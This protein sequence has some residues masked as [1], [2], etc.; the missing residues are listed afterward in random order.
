MLLLHILFLWDYWVQT[1]ESRIPLKPMLWGVRDVAFSS[2]SQ[3]HT[4]LTE[5][6][7]FQLCRTTLLLKDPLFRLFRPPKWLTSKTDIISYF[8]Q[9]LTKITLSESVVR[10]EWSYKGSGSFSKVRDALCKPNNNVY[11]YL[12]QH[13][14]TRCKLR[15]NLN[16]LTI[17][18]YTYAHTHPPR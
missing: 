14:D 10:R 18:T 6:A 16:L 15:Q 3:E 11:M 17:P 12:E 5:S 1:S 8:R 4:G 9:E 13:W 7:V 2:I